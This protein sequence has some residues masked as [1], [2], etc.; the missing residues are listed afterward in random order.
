M[1]ENREWIE[2]WSTKEATRRGG[3]CEERASTGKEKASQP[4]MIRTEQGLQKQNNVLTESARY[5]AKT[6]KIKPEGRAGGEEIGSLGGRGAR[7]NGKR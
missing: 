5:E 1:I 3:E 4:Q 7:G 6:Q 2:G